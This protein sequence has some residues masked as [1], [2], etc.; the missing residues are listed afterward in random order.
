M[1]KLIIFPSLFQQF[2][3]IPSLDDPPLLQYHDRIGISHGT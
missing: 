1:I 3:M 2:C